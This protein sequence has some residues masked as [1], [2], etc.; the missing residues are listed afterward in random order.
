VRQDTNT[1]G[2][3][4]AATADRQS[5]IVAPSPARPAPPAGALRTLVFA[6]LA[7]C[8]AFAVEAAPEREPVVNTPVYFPG[9]KSYFELVA[10]V[11]GDWDR[12]PSSDPVIRWVAANT[13]AQQ[14]MHKGVR[15]RLAVVKDRAVHDFLLQTFRPDNIT[16]IGLRYWCGV[17]RT[18]WVTGEFHNRG[19]F[20]A[21]DHLWNRGGTF[22]VTTPVQACHSDQPYWPVHYWGVDHGFRWNANGPLKAGRYYFVE[23]P[24]GKE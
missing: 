5:S 18:Q 14:R 23:Y 1:S 15:G 3:G 17:N 2:A 6:V 13:K 10:A 24:T 20:S 4:A 16:W 21:W 8:T 9:T 22:D 7:I 19:S 11:P 12:G